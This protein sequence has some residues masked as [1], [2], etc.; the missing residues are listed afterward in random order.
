MGDDE[1]AGSETAA[2]AAVVSMFVGE[3]IV[4]LEAGRVL[5]RRRP[6]LLKIC[7]V[8]KVCRYVDG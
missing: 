5:Y 8:P 6:C 2:A 4:N 1:R 7:Q 3:A